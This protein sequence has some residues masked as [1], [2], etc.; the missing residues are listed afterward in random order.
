[1]GHCEVYKTLWENVSWRNVSNVSV[2]EWSDSGQNWNAG[3]Q[4]LGGGGDI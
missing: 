2:F 1:M 4:K 3:P